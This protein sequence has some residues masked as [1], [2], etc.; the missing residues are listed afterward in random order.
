[1]RRSAVDSLATRNAGSYLVAQ[2]ARCAGVLRLQLLTATIAGYRIS[3]VRLGD[4]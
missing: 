2:L 1:M 3:P 4:G